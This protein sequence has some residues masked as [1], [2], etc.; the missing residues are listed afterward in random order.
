MSGLLVDAI[1]LL[2]H[3]ETVSGQCYIGHLDVAL[4]D[5]GRKQMEVSTAGMDGWDVIVT[6]PL[7]RCAEFSRQLAQ[8]LNIPLITEPDIREIGFGRW[9]GLD[10]KTIQARYPEQYRAFLNKPE[11]N[12]PPGGESLLIF[13]QRVLT[14]WRSLQQQYAGQKIL[15]VAH[16]GTIR[17]LLQ[18]IYSM[19]WAEVFAIS[20]AHGCIICIEQDSN[21]P[22]NTLPYQYLNQSA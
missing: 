3:G 8:R 6:S 7:I 12:T 16:G 20:V 9:E 21:N 18:E 2:R 14:A 15:L 4:S 11:E 17:I 19:L 10:A 22:G 13:R 5:L 1:Y